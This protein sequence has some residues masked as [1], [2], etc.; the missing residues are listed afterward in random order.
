M[1]APT[2]TLEECFSTGIEA[3]CHDNS[4]NWLVLVQPATEPYTADDFK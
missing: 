1:N 3:L 4:G 2:L